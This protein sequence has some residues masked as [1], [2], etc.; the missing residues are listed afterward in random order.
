VAMC[1]VVRLNSNSILPVVKELIERKNRVR[2]TVTG[3]SMYPFLRDGRDV[4]ELEQVKAQEVKRGDILL[5]QRRNGEYILHRLHHKAEEGLY[6]IGD[7]Q[8]WIEGPMND[9]QLIARVYA[10]V[11]KNRYIRSD[12]V[13]WHYL[14]LFWLL[15]RPFRTGLIRVYRATREFA[16]LCLINPRDITI[17]KTKKRR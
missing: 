15:L 7:A 6:L 9:E 10:V 8:Q 14:G 12:H 11:R 3:M 2:I 13:C 17:I 4:V 5:M 16:K 1:E